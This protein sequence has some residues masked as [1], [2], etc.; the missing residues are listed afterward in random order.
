[1]YAHAVMVA[2]WMRE[3]P[4]GEHLC[5]R[6]PLI[7]VALKPTAHVLQHE[8]G[9]LYDTIHT[10]MEKACLDYDDEL[11][12]ARKEQQHKSLES[13]DDED[14]QRK[15]LKG[16]HKKLARSKKKKKADID[17]DKGD[18]DDDKAEAKKQGGHKKLAR[19]KKK[20]ARSL[21]EEERKPKCRRRHNRRFRG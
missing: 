11:L 10:S 7:A 18:E 17:V 5:S 1:M 12:D 6:Q 4:G 9:V 20:K 13:P 8:H 2:A 16:E 21:E 15:F 19:S 14:D 3:C